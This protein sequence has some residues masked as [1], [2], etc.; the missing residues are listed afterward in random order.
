M[1]IAHE[2]LLAGH[3]GISKTEF[4]I[5]T[6]FYWP[7]IHQDIVHFCR[8]CDVCQRTIQKGKVVKAPLG[9]VPLI[10]TPFKRIALDLVG[11]IHPPSDRGNR[12]ILTIMDYA[13]RYPDATALA[14]IDTITVAEALVDM[15]SRIGV[16][17]EILS[18]QGTQFFSDL[19]REVCRLLSIR[20]L[21]STPY[22]PECNGLLERLVP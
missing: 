12:Y 7:G 14:N 11:P 13:T 17:S 15:Y 4:K 20:Q 5:L 1:K 6:Q 19:M 8:S 21:T 10:D 16:P 9:K 18:D 2:S 3:L 22:Y